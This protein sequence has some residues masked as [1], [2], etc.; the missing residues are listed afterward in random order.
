MRSWA[1]VRDGRRSANSGAR[2]SRLLPRGERHVASATSAFPNCEAN[3]SQSLEGPGEHQLR[4]RELA[5]GIA[6]R[7]G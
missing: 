5:Y 2:H 1:D 3:Q 4:I 6:F 7:W